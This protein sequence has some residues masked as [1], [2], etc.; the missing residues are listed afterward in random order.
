MCRRS[1]LLKGEGGGGEESN[2]TTAR[3][4][5]RLWII[6]YSLMATVIGGT[7]ILL[8]PMKLF[9]SFFLYLM[10]N[11]VHHFNRLIKRSYIY[12]GGPG[13]CCWSCFKG[14]VSQDLL[15][16]VFFVN[17][18][19]PSVNNV[20]VT[21]N[22]LENSRRYSQGAPPVYQRHWWQIIGTISDCWQ[23]KVNSKE[24]IYLQY[25]LTLLPKDFQTYN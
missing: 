8:R 16:Q 7:G 12:E 9:V 2:F 22:F 1:S 18:L 4:P 25:M 3:K 14:T 5:G 11:V 21:S 13:V 6:P 10:F 19:A 20:R 24:K 15:L 23:L 17:Q